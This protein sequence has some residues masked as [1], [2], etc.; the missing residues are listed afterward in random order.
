MG[1]LLRERRQDLLPES[2]S[3]T[4]PA[5]RRANTLETSR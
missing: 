3:S 4:A 2:P 5:A 1:H